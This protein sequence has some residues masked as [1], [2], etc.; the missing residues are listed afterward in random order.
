MRD[1]CIKSSCFPQSVAGYIHIH[2]LLVM[3][4]F[5]DPRKDLFSCLNYC[6]KVIQTKKEI[7]IHL[8]LYEAPKFVFENELEIKNCLSF[9]LTLY[10]FFFLWIPAYLLEWEIGSLWGNLAE[11]KYLLIEWMSEH[12]KL[13]LEG[14]LIAWSILAPK[15][16]QQSVV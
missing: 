3:R 5:R 13:Y 15:A 14:W 7:W 1:R 8:W 16:E 6:C 10:F 4:C 9:H 12:Q 11:D 2:Y